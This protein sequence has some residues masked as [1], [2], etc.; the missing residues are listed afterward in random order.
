MRERWQSPLPLWTAQVD[1]QGGFGRLIIIA[2][3]YAAV[4]TVGLLFFRRVFRDDPLSVVAAN[5]A[6]FVFAAQYFALFVGGCNA[7]YRAML[8]DYETR[9]LESHRLSPLSNTTVVAGYLLGPPMRMLVIFIVNLFIGGFLTGLAAMPIDMWVLGNLLLLLVAVNLWAMVICAGF[10]PAKPINPVP[11]LFVLSLAL[12]PVA[13]LPGLG[14]VSGIYAAFAAAGVMSGAI[15]L[16]AFASIGMAITAAVLSSFWFAAAAAKY[17]RPELPTLNALRGTILLVL[18]LF[19]ALLSMVGLAAA[20][21]Q[22]ATYV[23]P[24]MAEFEDLS[25]AQWIATFLTSLLVAAVPISGAVACRLLIRRGSAVRGWPDRVP[26]VAVTIVTGVLILGLSAGIGNK[27]WTVVLETRSAVAD[28]P[29]DAARIW[30]VTALVVFLTLFT[31]RGL[32][33]IVH[34]LRAN[35]ARIAVTV[36]LLLLWCLMP[37]ADLARVHHFSTPA[38]PLDFSALFD[39][40]P[41]GALITLWFDLQ[42]PRFAGLAFQAATT[43][44][45]TALG[46]W[47]CRRRFPTR[48]EGP[49]PTPWPHAEEA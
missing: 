13:M 43:V 25:P 23:S 20:Q 33:V 24:F 47:V 41:A 3:L 44:F 22:T 7:V 27:V 34:S 48:A 46:Q 40:S 31:L 12:V 15:T 29:K 38:K 37:L 30:L 42:L 49:L 21:S 18:W 39:A 28:A 32:C 26:D 2:I 36:P 8:R 4:F 6:N 11:V 14:L 5:M 16:P 19:A 17:R 10:R 45:I 1:L 9:M 35:A